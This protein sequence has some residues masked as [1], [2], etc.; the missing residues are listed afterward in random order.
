MG[1][2]EDFKKTAKILAERFKESDK[3]VVKIVSNLDTDGFL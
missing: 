3:N 1:G 2:R